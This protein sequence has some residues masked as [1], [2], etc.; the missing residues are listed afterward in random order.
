MFKNA[1]HNITGDIAFNAES[2]PMII[3]SGHEFCNTK[4]CHGPD[5]VPRG[6]DFMIVATGPECEQENKSSKG[7]E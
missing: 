1:I 3:S 4:V 5:D 2:F 6:E 7:V